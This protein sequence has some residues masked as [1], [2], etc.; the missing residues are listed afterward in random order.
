MPPAQRLLQSARSLW[1]LRQF[2]LARRTRG[3]RALALC[4][5]HQAVRAG[6]ML[7]FRARAGDLGRA[8]NRAAGVQVPTLGNLD[9]EGRHGMKKPGDRAL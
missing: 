8:G 6:D 9:N 2:E 1:N 7:I 3:G 4:V 5:D